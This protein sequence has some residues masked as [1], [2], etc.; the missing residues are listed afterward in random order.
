M[1]REAGMPRHAPSARVRLIFSPDLCAAERQAVLG[2]TRAFAKFGVAFDHVDAQK[3][4]LE[5]PHLMLYPTRAGARI[6]RAM[7]GEEL[8]ELVISSF[9]FYHDV[10]APFSKRSTWDDLYTKNVLGMGVTPYEIHGWI[11][12]LNRMVSYPGITRTGEAGIVSTHLDLGLK[13]EL[14]P[15][16]F[17]EPEPAPRLKLATIRAVV[18]HELAHLLGIDS[19]C[20]GKAGEC[21]MEAWTLHKQ[22]IKKVV[23]GGLGICRTCEDRIRGWVGSPGGGRA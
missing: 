20:E 9:V 5:T 14:T 19:H 6:H 18:R 7:R 2:A 16:R 21:L 10:T 12:Q 13:P 1:T 22:F 11:E 8:N 3:S 23:E 4:L 15:A 17:Q